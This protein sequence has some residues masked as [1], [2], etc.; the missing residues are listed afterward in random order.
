MATKTMKQSDIVRQTLTVIDWTPESVS[1]A[2]EAQ[3]ILGYQGLKDKQEAPQHG[4]LASV[5]A[6][7]GID[8]L[9]KDSVKKYQ[10]EKQNEVAREKFE[11]WIS[12]SETYRS[13]FWAP[14]WGTRKI[15][16]YKEAIPE[17]V[18]NKAVQIKRALP[19]VVIEV[20]YLEENPDPFLIVKTMKDKYS[21]DESYYVEVWD[22]PKFEGRVR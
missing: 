7:L 22:E 20:E 12:T 5:L 18:L 16:E 15:S 21:E 14:S 4:P 19:D 1:M 11:A 17:F 8:V 13:S 6:T 9:N 2:S 3:E 10:R